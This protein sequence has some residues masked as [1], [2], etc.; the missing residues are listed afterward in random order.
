S[1]K[2]IAADALPHIFEPFYTSK[3]GGLGLGLFVS[4]DIVQDHGGRIEVESRVG[5][6]TTF[7]IWLPT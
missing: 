7:T 6:G 1:G 5:E 2:G 3:R 4:Q